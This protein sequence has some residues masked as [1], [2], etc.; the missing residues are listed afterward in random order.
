MS[1]TR[2]VRALSLGDAKAAAGVLHIE[3]Q[4]VHFVADDGTTMT[5]ARDASFGATL[6]GSMVSLKGP[7]GEGRFIAAGIDDEQQRRRWAQVLSD[8]LVPP[9]NAPTASADVSFDDFA[10]GMNEKVSAKSS[11]LW[12]LV[13]VAAFFALSSGVQTLVM[14]SAVLLLHE[15][16][17]AL[18]MKVFGYRDL[19]VFF[20]PFVGAFTTGRGDGVAAWKRGVILLAGPIPGLVLAWALPWLVSDALKAQPWFASLIGLLLVLNGFN[21]LPFSPLDGGNLVSL[22]LFPKSPRAETAASVGSGLLL[23]TFFAMTQDWLLVAVAALFAWGSFMSRKIAIEALALRPDFKGAS[24]AFSEL[25]KELQQTLFM[26]AS[27]LAVDSGDPS[28]ESRPGAKLKRMTAIGRAL[29]YRV[30]ADHPGV[31]ARV[32]LLVAYIVALASVGVVL[33]RGLWHKVIAQI[34]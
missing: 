25:P 3:P 29:L 26:R 12:M 20:L 22:L 32:I 8:Q 24:A 5:F 34:S 9:P 4:R 19:R 17:H 23:M 10:H 15:L 18:A 14:F 33:Y 27:S 2:K 13:S 7:E 31:R 21:L 11:K 16:G 30:T 6:D 1:V 28:R